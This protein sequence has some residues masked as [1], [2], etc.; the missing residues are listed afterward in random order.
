M[1]GVAVKSGLLTRRSRPPCQKISHSVISTGIPTRTTAHLAAAG[2]QRA[3]TIPVIDSF[4]PYVNW[5]LPMPGPFPTPGPL[6]TPGHPHPWPPPHIHLGMSS[7]TRS[8][9]T[10]TRIRQNMSTMPSPLGSAPMRSWKNDGHALGYSH[11]GWQR[12]GGRGS[13]RGRGA[14]G[15]R[16]RGCR[17]ERVS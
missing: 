2:P 3:A 7:V 6:P 14:P 13:S 8:S 10:A 16:R 11:C 4:N 12:G 1:T 15:G 17:E 5:P 9:S